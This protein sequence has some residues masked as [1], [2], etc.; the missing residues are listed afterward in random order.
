MYLPQSNPHRNSGESQVLDKYGA[1]VPFMHMAYPK[2]LPSWESYLQSLWIYLSSPIKRIFL[3]H[4]RK[5]PFSFFLAPMAAFQHRC[6]PRGRLSAWH[7][8]RI[9]HLREI[10]THSL[11]GTSLWEGRVTSIWQTKKL[12]WRRVGSLAQGHM[13]PFSL[14]PEPTLSAVL[15][16]SPLSKWPHRQIN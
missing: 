10:R 16:L 2:C 1:C 12:E 6:W 11:P 7:L 5:M 8:V 3:N 4:H 9:K 15:Q 14:T 13:G